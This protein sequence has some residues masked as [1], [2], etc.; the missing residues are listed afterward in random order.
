M[1]TQLR[2]GREHND[3][4]PKK[5]WYVEPDGPIQ[6]TKQ[7][8]LLTDRTSIS[9]AE[10]FALAMR[11]LPHVTVIG[12]FTS[13]CFADVYGDRLPNGWQFS[14]SYKL[15]VDGSGFC[16]EGIGVPPD[17]RKISTKE[18]VEKGRDEVL[19]LAI[20]LLNTNAIELQDETG[21]QE[22]IRESL[23]EI[24]GQDIKAKGIDSALNRFHKSKS[25]AAN[26]YY[27]DEDDL[28]SL[29]RQLL[30][31]GKVDGAIAVFAI[32]VD[33]FPNSI[34]CHE[35]L[36]EAYFE[37]DKIELGYAHYRKSLEIN[38]QS[39]PW[40]KESYKEAEKVLAGA[41]ILHKV[42]NRIA[43]GQVIRKKVKSYYQ[44]PT[45]YYVAENQMNR[46]GYKFLGEE[47]VLE[48]IEV[49]KIN[50]KEFPESWNVYDSLGEAYMV[51]GDK[52]LAIKNYE[53]S[54]ALNP[55]NEN[56]IKALKELMNN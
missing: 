31:D 55:S 49:F 23:V 16:W 19:D 30:N 54:V 1:T 9:A 36:A 35:N 21:S 20:A 27:V 42:L 52:E 3:F 51:N 39:Y 43:D 25:S 17:I 13:G 48:A 6:A 12:D 47:K 50:A 29:G 22:D 44:N 11:V 40:E 41:K 56:G 34:P 2:N 45:A 38:R 53:K 8:V 18:N 26:A 5:Y 46:L 32:G 7:V 28:I 37:A 14:C 15:F 33:E 24:L 4:T 10:N